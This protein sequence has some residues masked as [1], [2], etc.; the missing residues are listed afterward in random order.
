VQENFCLHAKQK[1]IALNVTVEA[2][3]PNLMGSWRMVRQILTN[4]VSNALKFTS[5]RGTVTITATLAG[6]G[7]LLISVADTGIGMSEAEIAI[8]LTPFGQVDGALSRSHEGTG[9][10]LPLARAMAK[11]HQ[12][13]FRI[14]S[15]R[16]AGTS[17]EI[18]F[19]AA[20]LIGPVEQPI[21]ASA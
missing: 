11:L 4:L 21:S 18:A 2:G 1:D 14:G 7:E 20:R 12:A 13:E 5:D 8:A 19:P 10:G 3:L 17:V 16:G 15:V 9:L 6:G